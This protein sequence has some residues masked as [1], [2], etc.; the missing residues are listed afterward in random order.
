MTEVAFHFNA[1]DKQA[2]ACR[3]LRKAVAGGARFVWLRDRELDAEA[4]RALARDLIA[5]LAPVGGRLVVGGERE[6][7]R[8]RELH[9]ELGRGDL[10]ACRALGG[11]GDEPGR[12]D[13][14]A[15]AEESELLERDVHGV[16]YRVQPSWASM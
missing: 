4:R 2:Y 5:I 9:G 8:A 12:G 11:E 1:P 13:V 3:L 15:V 14:A 16:P 6:G 7:I 10:C